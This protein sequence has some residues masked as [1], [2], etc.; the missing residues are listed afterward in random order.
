MTTM[1]NELIHAALNAPAGLDGLA[2][3][4]A[5][6]AG[7]EPVNDRQGHPGS[8]SAASHAIRRSDPARRR[9]AVRLSAT[10]RR[11]WP[12]TWRSTAGPGAA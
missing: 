12:A 5:Y 3:D 11:P 9:L 1:D 2:S 4:M 8:S 6:L 7:R 10:P